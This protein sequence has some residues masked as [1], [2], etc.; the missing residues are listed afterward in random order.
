MSEN[1]SARSSPPDGT[2]RLEP[3][4]CVVSPMRSAESGACGSVRFPLPWACRNV[5]HLRHDAPRASRQEPPVEL[6]RAESLQASGTERQACA[7]PHRKSGY[8]RLVPGHHDCLDNDRL[9]ARY[10]SSALLSL[11][12]PSGIMVHTRHCNSCMRPGIFSIRR[13]LHR[14][15][16]PYVRRGR[17]RR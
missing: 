11:V 13:H 6:V 17:G 16:R 10:P 7:S 4:A 14:P 2:D 9:P 5:P 1:E 12:R 8:R 15:E 3:D